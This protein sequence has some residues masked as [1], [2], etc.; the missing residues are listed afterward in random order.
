MLRAWR[1]ICTSGFVSGFRVSEATLWWEFQ[2]SLLI[3]VDGVDF[4]IHCVR[5]VAVV[6]QPEHV[7]RCAA[8]IGL[9]TRIHAGIHSAS[10]FA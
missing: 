5:L 8:S 7:R 3:R 10:T 6:F 2:F 1:S 4:W 9:F